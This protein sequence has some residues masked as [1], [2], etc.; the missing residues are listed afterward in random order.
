[1]FEIYAEGELVACKLGTLD[2]AIQHVQQDYKD[3]LA[4]KEEY[5]DCYDADDQFWF[6]VYEIK[7]VVDVNLEEVI[8]TNHRGTFPKSW[9]AEGENFID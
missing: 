8:T 1:M 5:P 7:Q 3:F 6:D 2:E 4:D 9:R